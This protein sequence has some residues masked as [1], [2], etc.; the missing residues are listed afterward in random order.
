M[1][2]KMKNIN[3]PIILIVILTV[4]YSGCKSNSVT[5]THSEHEEL[6][7]NM[8]EFSVEQYNT[9]GIVLDSLNKKQISKIVSVNGTITVPP[10]SYATVCTSFGGYIKSSSL[11]EGSLVSKGQ[12]L[13]MI[14][15]SEFVDLQQNYLETKSKFAYAETEY[16]R[17]KELN[18]SNVNSE[19][20][21][22][23]A[24]L[25]Y[26]TL[27]AQLNGLIQKLSILNIDYE[28]LT[29]D[30]IKSVLP[31]VSPISGYVKT[32]NINIGKYINTTDILFEIVNTGK[33]TLE[34]IVFENDL[35]NIKEG[36]KLTF[37]MPNTPDIS[38]E[39][40]ILQ[41]GK[42]LD[43]DKTAK[44]YATIDKSEE[45]LVTGMYV[46]AK[47]EV[48]NSESLCL[49]SESIVQFDE[50]FY[51]FAFKEKAMEDG[52]E[53]TLF[54][55]IE[56]EKGSENYG[57]TE[58]IFKNEID[59]TSKQYVTKGAYAILSKYKNSGEMSC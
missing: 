46:N 21:L 51:V 27:K 30:N 56:I 9:A 35:Q 6:P 42:T 19:K 31:L 18:T 5:E 57:F 1:K 41:V 43:S 45:N 40:T 58:I 44:V 3:I 38:Y 36:Q 17:Q 22:Q 53:I 12:V 29:E 16:N 34:L 49:P 11:M 39:A 48:T 13:A 23:L 52:K 4:I 24:E 10:Q 15:N 59:N 32:V 47:I 14:E 26:K 50:K 7:P 25:E 8:V 55:A 20:T 2:M 28:K 54:E 33:L 37:S